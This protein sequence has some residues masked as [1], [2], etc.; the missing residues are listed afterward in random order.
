MNE[1]YPRCKT[2]VSKSV[3]GVSKYLVVQLAHQFEV[4][5][6]PLQKDHPVA[7]LGHEETEGQGQIMV[8]QGIL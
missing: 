5:L 3:K 6:A 7:L 1:N 8:Q 4:F 2:S